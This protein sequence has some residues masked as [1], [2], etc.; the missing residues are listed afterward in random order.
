MKLKAFLLSFII[1]MLIWL[2][3]TGT[4]DLPMLLTGAIS[5]AIIS[6]I[7][8]S[9]C[10]IF[11]GLKLTPA[12]FFYTIVYLFVFLYELIRSNLDVARRVL[13][14]S[15]PIN[16][17]IVDVKTRLKSPMARMILTNSI[18]LTP[19][20]LTVDI[21]DDTLFIHW[22]DVSSEDREEAT[23]KIVNR[24]E[25]IISKIYD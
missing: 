7:L 12:A 23:K 18:T 16:P 14:P 3:L 9:R 13:S 22:I 1:L 10:T 5:A 2:L 19:G 20:T 11:K 6:L 21:E 4:F 15:L 25:N 17:G 24:F 8:C